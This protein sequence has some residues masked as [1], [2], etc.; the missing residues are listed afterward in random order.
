MHGRDYMACYASDLAA[1]E[2]AGQLGSVVSL[3]MFYRGDVVA[4]LEDV[5]GMDIYLAIPVHVP[6]IGGSRVGLSSLTAR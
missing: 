6:Y 4:R 3:Y 5:V 2:R 1:L